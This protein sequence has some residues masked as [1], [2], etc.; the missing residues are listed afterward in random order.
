[1]TPSTEELRSTFR[2]PEENAVMRW[3]LLTAPRWQVLLAIML[4][5]YAVL[6]ALGFVNPFEMRDLLNETNAA[7]TLFSSLLSGAIL[8]VSVVVSI[9]SVV[10]S[11]EMTDLEDQQMR[12]D[13]SMDYHREIEG[14]IEAEIAPARPAD[15]LS[16]VLYAL[17]NQVA[18]LTEAAAESSNDEFRADVEEFADN[19]AEEIEDARATLSEARMGSFKVL[20]AG[21]KYNYSGELHA[22]R[23]LRHKHGDDLSEETQDAI[24]ELIS[25]LKHVGTGREYFKS[26]YYKRELAY[27]SSR[28]LFVSLPVIVFTSYVILAL[29]A[30][31]FPEVVIIGLS[32][33]VFFVLFAYTIALAPYIL[34]TAYV[35][36]AATITIRTLAGGPFILQEGSQIASLEWDPDTPS[37]EWKLS[38]RTDEE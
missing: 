3:M 30:A 5:I 9:N 10:L 28:L 37:R 15:F 23:G 31:L 17:S 2:R 8:L 21:L 24:D 32:P 6:I 22:A 18:A 27:L 26:L 35:I 12:I 20:L 33:L 25:T 34:L 16:A 7:K 1:M 11:Q 13:A 29:D 4:G 38:E 19:V 36:R 14:F